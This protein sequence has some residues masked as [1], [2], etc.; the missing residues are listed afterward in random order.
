[1]FKSLVL[2][3][4]LVL[5]VAGVASATNPCHANVQAVRQNVVVQ[6]QVV[7]VP[8]YQVQVVQPQIVQAVVQPAYVQQVQFVQA[9]NHH[10]NN[11]FLR[12][13]QNRGRSVQ[14]QRIVTR[15]R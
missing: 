6:Q 5:G 15:N 2:S 4:M 9:N 1:M 12:Q 10:N 11:Q 7:A 3:V 13:N 8:A 14:S